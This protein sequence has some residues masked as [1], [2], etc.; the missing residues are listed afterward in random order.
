MLHYEKTGIRNDGG[1]SPSVDSFMNGL[2]LELF[3]MPRIRKDIDK[4]EHI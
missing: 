4:K 3:H 1:D 2:H